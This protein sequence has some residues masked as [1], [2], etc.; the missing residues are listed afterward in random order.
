MRFVLDSNI[1]L[2]WVL[3]EADSAKAIALRDDFRSKVH[4]L[5]SPDI[6]PVEVA[7]ALT[8]AER[9]GILQPGEAAVRLSRVLHF[10]PVFH[11]F[12]SLLP[13]AVELSSQTRTG[14]YD[15]L[16]V[17]LAEQEQCEVVT[18]DQRLVNNLKGFPIRELSTV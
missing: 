2:K 14:V 13:R 5:I 3:P 6:L 9:K 12:I 8:R 11:P 10:S 18:A 16:Y 17:A 4:E 15:C 1:A 7:H